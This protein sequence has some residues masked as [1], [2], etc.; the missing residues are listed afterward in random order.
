[1]EHYI[2]EAVLILQALPFWYDQY[3]DHVLWERAPL[4][5]WMGVNGLAH[6]WMDC[7]RQCVQELQ[8]ASEALLS[9]YSCV[10]HGVGVDSI[11]ANALLAS[12]VL[13]IYYINF[14]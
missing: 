10:P 1:M 6:R 8:R 4:S 13:L 7:Q 9:P 12:M 2:R 14:C 11:V 3:P 5:Q